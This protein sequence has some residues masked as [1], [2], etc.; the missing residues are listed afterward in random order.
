MSKHE[1]DAAIPELRLAVKN[2]PTSAAEHR[3]LGQAL[4]LLGHQEEAVRELQSAVSLNPDSDLSHRYLGT[5]LFELQRYSEAEKEF[6]QAV[7]LKSTGD[8][9]YSLAACLMTMDRYQEALAELEIAS[10]LDPAQSLYRAR[11]DE[12]IKLMKANPR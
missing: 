6:R 9:H 11:K 1:Y 12:L 3:T 8:N 7:R 2:N 10:H 4:L 5:A